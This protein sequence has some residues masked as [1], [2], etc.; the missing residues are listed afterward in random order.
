MIT[1]KINN[2]TIFQLVEHLEQYLQ[3][4]RKAI[5]L[6]L[7]TFFS[8]G[9]LLLED[10]P[11]FGK[12]TLALAVSKAL[13]LDFKR[14]QCTN[15]LLPSDILGTT[16]FNKKSN[17]FEFKKGPIFTN[18][19]LIDEINRASPKTQSALLEAMEESQITIDGN[20]Y[21][22]PEPFFVIATQNPIEHFGTFNLP[23]SQLDRFLINTSIGY[24]NPNIE[25]E[26]LLKGSSREKLIDLNSVITLEQIYDC[27]NEIE[28][29]LVSD[30]IVD[31]IIIVANKI[32]ES[33]EIISGLST[34]GTLHILNASKTF[35]F[36]QGRDYV[37]HEDVK[38]LM[39]YIIPHRIILK[40]ELNLLET[41]RA[42]I[43]RIIESLE[44]GY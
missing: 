25:K 19:L 33:N 10:L 11:G 3:G 23:D 37:I 12:T 15:D 21:K 18:I 42:F 9:H 1:L 36:F 20:L 29:V 35:A 44:V 39:E 38:F 17:K 40:D 27:Y 34:R 43:K 7:I 28:K 8:K 41:K 31:Y 26:I 24:P 4:K 22:L 13:G 30:K 6:T 2:K 16:I 14:I 5:I 32:R